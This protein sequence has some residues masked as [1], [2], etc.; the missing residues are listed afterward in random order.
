MAGGGYRIECDTK[1]DTWHSSR[2]NAALENGGDE[3]KHTLFPILLFVL[4]NVCR[5]RHGCPG[6]R[7]AAPYGRG[8]PLCP[9][10]PL[11]HVVGSFS[12]LCHSTFSHSTFGHS[13]FS[14]LMLGL[15]TFGHSVFVHSTFSLSTL[16]S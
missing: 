4:A 16:S 8:G 3:N 9:H 10:R 14:H 13:T 6:Y 1:K 12:T 2:Q 15:L 11:M 5:G 7:G